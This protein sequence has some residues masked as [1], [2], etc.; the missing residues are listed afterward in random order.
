[1]KTLLAAGLLLLFA[2]ARAACDL[3]TW[4]APRDVDCARAWMDETA[5]SNLAMTSSSVSAPTSVQRSSSGIARNFF[6]S[7]GFRRSCS[8][9]V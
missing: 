8:A 5:S 4:Q 3:T 7:S 9:Q 1:M 6:A 2:Q